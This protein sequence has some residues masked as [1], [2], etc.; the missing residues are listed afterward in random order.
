[1]GHLGESQGH[2]QVTSPF[3]LILKNSKPRQMK[4]NANLVGKREKAKT[5]L[6]HAV[7]ADADVMNVQQA[8]SDD[9]SIV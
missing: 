5:R 7:G 9:Y 1:M 3:E 4:A 2:S 6:S 8:R